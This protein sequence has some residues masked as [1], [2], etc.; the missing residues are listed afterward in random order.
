MNQAPDTIKH[1]RDIDQ[2]LRQFYEQL[3]DLKNLLRKI[4]TH[5]R[6]LNESTQLEKEIIDF[7]KKLAEQSEETQKAIQTVVSHASDTFPTLT[8]KIGLEL[9]KSATQVREH[10]DAAQEV[11]KSVSEHVNN[12]K[13][14]IKEFSEVQPITH[15]QLDE[16]RQLIFSGI[17]DRLQQLE[18][19]ILLIIQDSSSSLNPLSAEK[20]RPF[21][22]HLEREVMERI[23][24]Q[25]TRLEASY[26]RFFL[27]ACSLVL[28][29]LFFQ[30][31]F[32][33]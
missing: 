3:H 24:Q 27:M 22:N 21:L 29:F 15:E 18:K 12:L 11:S 23:E 14:K 5:E 26:F 7:L 13:E 4:Q 33:K 20:V 19:K 31:L 8:E 10:L 17:E 32:G 6:L 9:Q 2:Q 30:W 16:H 25:I 1:F 28:A